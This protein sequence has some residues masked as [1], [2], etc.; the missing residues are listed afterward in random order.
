M[1]RILA[2]I[3]LTGS[4]APSIAAQ[5]SVTIESYASDVSRPVSALLN[6]VRQHERIAVTYE[7]PRYSKRDDMQGPNTAFTYSVQGLHAQD[8]VEVTIARMLREYA[9]SGGLTYSV[10]RDGTRLD[11]V[12]NQVLDATGKR[13]RQ[14]SI[15]DTVISVPA[16]QRD[17]GQ[18]LQAICDQIKKQAGYEIDIGPSAPANALLSYSTT[19]GIDNLTAHAALAWLLDRVSAPGSF[20]WDLYYDPADGGY[21]LNF[22]YVGHAGRV[23]K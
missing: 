6:Q 18:L 1:N 10:V 3:V 5:D 7:D 12:P 9:A 11:V 15:L 13:I 22:A 20:V 8:G 21:G 14:G 17:G 23:V 16:G 4:I 19:E 2:L